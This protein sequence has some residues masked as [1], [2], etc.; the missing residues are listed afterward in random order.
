MIKF[1]DRIDLPFNDVLYSL[2][3]VRF[4]GHFETQFQT[5]N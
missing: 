4:Q 5:S 1:K 3:K 2:V